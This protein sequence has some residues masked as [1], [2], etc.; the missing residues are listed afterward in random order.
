MSAVPA[1]RTDNAVK[2]RWASLTKKHPELLASSPSSAPSASAG[3]TFSDSSPSLSQPAYTSPQ[4]LPMRAPGAPS[5]RRFL[6]H[7]FDNGAHQRATKT[8]AMRSACLSS[9]S[10]Y[11]RSKN[12]TA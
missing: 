8:E 1:Y 7:V 5:E 9:V 2:N 12:K 3:S 10:M 6:L 4:S 11:H